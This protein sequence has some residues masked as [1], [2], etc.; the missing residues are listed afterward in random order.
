MQFWRPRFV[1]PQVAIINGVDTLPADLNQET[2]NH[3]TAKIEDEK[4]ERRKKK[5]AKE[6]RWEALL[7]RWKTLI[8]INLTPSP[9]LAKHLNKCAKD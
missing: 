3:L 6:E 8:T 5:K 9:W 1:S 7:R 2:M 4:G